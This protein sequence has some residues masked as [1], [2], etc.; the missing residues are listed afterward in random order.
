MMAIWLFLFF[1]CS[2][3]SASDQCDASSNEKALMKQIESLRTALQEKENHINALNQRLSEQRRSEY[4]SM[5]HAPDSPGSMKQKHKEEIKQQ[6]KQA[7]MLKEKDKQ[8]DKLQY[9][10]KEK[11]DKINRLFREANK[12]REKWEE[13]QM[14]VRRLQR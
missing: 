2:F 10:L 1:A 7:K 5:H 14:T 8:I 6:Q 3:G 9:L 12:Y 4:A 13:A 11:E